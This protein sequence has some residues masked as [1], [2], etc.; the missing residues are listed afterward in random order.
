VETLPPTVFDRVLILPGGELT[1]AIDDVGRLLVRAL[2][3]DNQPVPAYATLSPDGADGEHYFPAGR[4]VYVRAGGY[5]LAV[6]VGDSV[7][8]RRAFEVAPGELRTVSVGGTGFVRA[9][10]PGLPRLAGIEVELQ[11]YASG[12]SSALL[13][14]RTSVPV[15]AGEYR[16]VV[17]S[18]PVYVQER[19]LVA[20]A[21]TSTLVLPGLGTLQVDLSDSAGRP[22][23]VL[24]TLLRPEG[25]AAGAGEP[26]PGAVI[27]TFVSGVKQAVLTGTYDLLL[28]TVPS[29]LE[30][31][32]RVQPGVER[33]VSIAIPAATVGAEGT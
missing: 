4:P 5:R 17:R 13:P 7:A 9:R 16:A 28:E 14:W 12:S 18:L 29:R 11:E 24:V 8:L 22:L 30:R 25:M 15:P 33:V 6:E 19:F 27:G 21:E 1:L 10:A 26:A 23:S 2:S 20:P 3:P 32:I 31:G